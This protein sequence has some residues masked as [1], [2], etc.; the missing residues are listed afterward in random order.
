M[1]RQRQWVLMWFCSVLL[2]ILP[3][4]VLAFQMTNLEGDRV[5]LAQHVGQGKW[6]LVQF[7][8]LDCIACR[9]QKPLLDALH[10]AHRNTGAQVLGVVI[11]GV[12]KIDAIRNRLTADKTSYGH[13]V[14]FSDVY[15][16]QIRESSGVPYTATPTYWL[17]DP[18]GELFARQT[19]PMTPEAFADVER[20]VAGGVLPS[21]PL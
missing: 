17:I 8:S 21:A 16:R 10:Q 6:T 5:H 15:M 4:T 3:G 1:R 9:Q 7:W 18:N 12:E 19:G 13:L 11:D 20:I 2:P 14:A